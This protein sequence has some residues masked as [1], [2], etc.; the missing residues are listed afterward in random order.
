MKHLFRALIF[1]VTVAIMFIY[2]TDYS[3][4][5]PVPCKTA[6]DFKVKD[7]NGKTH[8]LSKMKG[9]SMVILYF[10]DVES[11]SSQEGMIDI[12]ELSGNYRLF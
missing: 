8:D 10:F 3:H 4:S 9:R 12:D 5:Q 6:P 7:T 2:G 11:K 1:V